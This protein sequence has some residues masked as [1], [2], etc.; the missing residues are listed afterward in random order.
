MV[1]GD[2]LSDEVMP[3]IRRCGPP[4]TIVGRLTGKVRPSLSDVR[5]DQAHGY[6]FNGFPQA[7]LLGLVRDLTTYAY[8]A[9]PCA[10]AGYL[11]RDPANTGQWQHLRLFESLER[12]MSS[13]SLKQV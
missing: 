4:A 7:G 5:N 1:V 11:D 9:V 2:Y 12:K 6:P 8:R 10:T 3:M 13:V